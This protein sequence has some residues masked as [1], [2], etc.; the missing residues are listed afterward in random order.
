MFLMLFQ[1]K[2]TNVIA[3]KTYS[4]AARLLE[5][6]STRVSDNILDKD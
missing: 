1:K 6:V 4:L 5:K 3:L 2:F